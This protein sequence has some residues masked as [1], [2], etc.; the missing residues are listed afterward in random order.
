MGPSGVGDAATTKVN[1]MGAEIVRLR[2]LLDR[3]TQEAEQLRAALEMANGRVAILEA[4]INS[5]YDT[6]M[7]SK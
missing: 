2:D 6:V 5:V 1:E 4:C 3:S 7:A